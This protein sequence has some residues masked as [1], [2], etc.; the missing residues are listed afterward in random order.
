MTFGLALSV[1]ALSLL[2]TPPSTPMEI[3]SDIVGFAFSFLILVF[4]WV[5]YTR[6]MSVLPMETSITL[7]LNFLML[8]LV[9]LEPYLFYLVS[10]FGR[11]GEYQLVEYAST[12]YAFDMGGLMAILGFF[13]HELS[14]EEKNLVSQEVL[15]RH[16][17]VRNVLFV[18]AVMFSLTALPQFW[19]WHIDDVPLRFYFWLSP[20]AIAWIS[21]KNGLLERL[22]RAHVSPKGS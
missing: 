19:S 21:S 5:S 17:R 7:F 9:V 10:Q 18:S 13:N 22:K 16:K 20:L 15:P 3:R 14:V 12:L 1:G 8:F 4:V 2:S 6:V 11:A